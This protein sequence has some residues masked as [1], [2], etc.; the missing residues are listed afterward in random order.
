MNIDYISYLNKSRFFLLANLKVLIIS[1]IVLVFSIETSNLILQLVF[2]E[3][4]SSFESKS[5]KKNFVKISE[6]PFDQNYIFTESES[7]SFLKAPE[8][9]LSLKLFGVTSSSDQNF[10]IIGLN[11]GDQRKYIAGESIL[12]NVFLESIHKDYV[13]INRSGSS[14]SLSFDT[15]SLIGGMPDAVLSNSE[16]ALKNNVISSQWLADQDISDLVSFVPIITDGVLAGLE[17]N[18]GADNKFFDSFD[19]EVGDILIAVN[20]MKISEFDQNYSSS[21]NSI[22]SESSNIDLELIRNKN[23]F[24]VGI[25]IN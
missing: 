16:K 22:F 25:E 23:K 13:T 10:A 9:S 11:S 2:S 3:G 7:L 12:E 15:L 6:N 4:T 14:E 18:P 1:F 20:G 17:L 21:L 19:L 24:K 8:T 5:S